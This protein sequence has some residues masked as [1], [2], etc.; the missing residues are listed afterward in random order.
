MATYEDVV[1]RYEQETWGRCAER[2]SD[3]F[4]GLTKQMIPILLKTANVNGSSTE[5][6]KL[7]P[8][9]PV[10]LLQ[11]KF[12]EKYGKKGNQHKN[13]LLK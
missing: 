12:V 9:F 10:L 8:L 13:E 7:L 5:F 6:V 2:Y 11:W 4:A 1:T 3:T